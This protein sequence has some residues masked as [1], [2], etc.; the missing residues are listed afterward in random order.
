MSC[1]IYSTGKTVKAFQW[2]GTEPLEDVH[3]LFGGLVTWG[4]WSE[5]E[6]LYLVGRVVR[7]GE[8]VIEGNGTATAMTDEEFRR[9]YRQ[10]VR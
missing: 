4:P 2:L 6:V 9:I 7:P 3:E 8:W 10:E 5:G 1:G